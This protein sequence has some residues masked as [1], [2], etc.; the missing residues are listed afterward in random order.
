MDDSLLE[1]KSMKLKKILFSN[2]MSSEK[3]K[4]QLLNFD[5]EKPNPEIVDSVGIFMDNVLEHSDDDELIIPTQDEYPTKNKKNNP[6]KKLVR[7][8]FKQNNQK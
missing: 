6:I 7:K 3:H 1:E 2:T 4:H 5:I 8:I